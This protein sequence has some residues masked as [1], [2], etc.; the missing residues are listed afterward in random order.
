MLCEKT[1]SP[2]MKRGVSKDQ[3]G[4]RR[5][6]RPTCGYPYGYLSYGAL[7]GLTDIRTDTLTPLGGR[8]A[9]RPLLI[10]LKVGRMPKRTSGPNK[11][12]SIVHRMSMSHESCEMQPV[13]S[14]VH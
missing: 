3:E 4:R 8:Q 7:R 14:Q 9:S 1:P 13:L 5:L 12:M 10:G 2:E 11:L 6:Q